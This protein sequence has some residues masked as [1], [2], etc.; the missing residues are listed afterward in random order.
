MEKSQ[1]QAHMNSTQLQEKLDT[2]RSRHQEL[3]G[4]LMSMRN[5]LAQKVAEAEAAHVDNSQIREECHQ[6]QESLSNMED[7]VRDA[8]R[9]VLALH[10]VGGKGC[11]FVRVCVGGGEIIILFLYLLLKRAQCFYSMLCTCICWP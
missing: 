11:I 6:A 4:E 7:S 3:E 5:K 10:Q 1:Q 8:R 9:T 2:A